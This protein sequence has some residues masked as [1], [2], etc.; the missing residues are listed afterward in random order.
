[1]AL[2]WSNE[3]YVRLYRPSVDHRALCWQ[4]RAIWPLLLQ[5]A[6]GA[7]VLGAR[8]G[9]AALARA[10]DVPVEVAEAGIADL[11]DDGCLMA[12]P[13]GYVIRNYV[14]AQTAIMSDSSRKARQREVDRAVEAL[15]AAAAMTSQASSQFGHATSRDVTDGHGASRDV[16]PS[17][18]EP[19][20]EENT[21]TA[22]ARDHGAPPPPAADRGRDAHAVVTMELHDAWSA[23][24]RALTAELGRTATVGGAMPTPSDMAT[25]R[26][27]VVEWAAVAG[28]ED[29]ELA[30]VARD[31]MGKLLAVRS[32]KARA[33]KDS[34]RWWSAPTFWALDGIKRDLADDPEA[35]AARARGRPGDGQPRRQ[36]HPARGQAPAIVSPHRPDGEIP[37]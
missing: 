22:G 12:M 21:H 9:V 37:L 5:E 14:D 13:G 27:V 15:T 20:R 36:P 26:A 34:L 1:M 2:D 30:D 18:A 7:G 25:I 23:A 10:I 11:L 33:D 17:R 32:A 16:T 35:V 31:R 24:G 6:D 29:R 19:S 4:A 8:K 3:R 28:A